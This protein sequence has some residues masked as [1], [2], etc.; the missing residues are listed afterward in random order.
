MFKFKL[1]TWIVIALVLGAFVGY[2]ND[3]FFLPELNPALDPMEDPAHLKRLAL[4]DN[5][6]IL[7]EMFLR[8]IKMIIAP[9]IFSTL[10]V[11]IARMGNMQVVGRVGLK[12]LLWFVGASF[13]S[14]LVGLFFIN[15]FNPGQYFDP[16][17]LDTLADRETGI[18][19]EGFSLRSFMHEIVPQSVVE[20]MATNSVLQIVVFSVFFGI[21]C[22]AVG[23]KAR[24]L[25]DVI[26]ELSFVIIK[27]TSYVMNLA[28]VAVFAAIAAL[29]TKEGLVPLLKLGIF[30]GEF[31]FSLA[32][33]WLLMGF[34]AFLM[35][36]KR[37][38]RLVHY[39]REPFLLAFGTA[40]SEAAYPKTLEGMNKFGVSKKISS[41][42]LPVG[43]SFNLDGSMMYCAFA[44]IFIAQIAGIDLSFGT[45]V[46]M[47]LLLMVT[48][49]GIAGVPR[50]ALVV[51]AATL[52]TFNL[53]EGGVALLLA[54]DQFLD[55][56]RSATNVVGN[57][58]ASVAIAKWEG[59]LGEENPD[60]LPDAAV[61]E[62][63]I[64]REQ[65]VA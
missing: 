25:I 45:Q 48:S 60:L 1:T 14:I 27:V 4:A 64:V 52:S 23:E 33:L 30:I 42:V 56:G 8:F 63:N 10:V 55:M 31:Y 26:E 51:I 20:A 18:S 2:L 54:V 61:S 36:G 35:V 50:A 21:A 19:N 44:V 7:S 62:P 17:I 32:M 22:A 12:T 65:S 13:V 40:S 34:I 11:G 53:P 57:G 6:S 15:L 38:F 59:E 37:V 41:F 3:Q 43:Y 28:P 24:R 47:L 58:L 29:V 9:L 46:T 49:K 16:H 39:L 5:I